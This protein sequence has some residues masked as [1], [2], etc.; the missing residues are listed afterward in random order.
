MKFIRNTYRI[1]YTQSKIGRLFSFLLL[2]FD[3][4]HAH[5][6]KRWVAM[7]R[8]VWDTH[9][10]FSWLP[11][12]YAAQCLQIISTLMGELSLFRS[13]LFSCILSVD[14]TH[15]RKTRC[16][17][18]HNHLNQEFS[19]QIDAPSIYKAKVYSKK[20]NQYFK[21]KEKFTSFRI[22]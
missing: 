19:I 3:D 14:S 9:A 11:N 5:T 16:V 22:A 21:R 2:L 18:A 17:R 12:A 15:G 4:K 6:R 13:D 10:F 8:K 1:L 20:I 7:K